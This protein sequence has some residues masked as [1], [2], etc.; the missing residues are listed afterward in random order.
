MLACDALPPAGQPFAAQLDQKN[1]S[2]GC[3]PKT[4]LKWLNEGKA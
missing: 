2:L 3:G 1:P 4:G